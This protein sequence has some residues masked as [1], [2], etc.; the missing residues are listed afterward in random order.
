MV[1]RPAVTQKLT[2]RGFFKYGLRLSVLGLLGFGFS[3]R[4][5]IETKQLN[6]RFAN[7][8]EAFDGFRIVQIS[9]LHASFWVGK[10]YLDRVIAR[11][12]TLNKDLVVITGDIITGSV[13]DF[14][15]RWL[16]SAG[17]GYI[18]VVTDVLTRLNAGPRFAVLGNHD[19][20]DGKET[21]TQL[22]GELERIGIDVLRNRSKT[23]NRGKDRITIAGTDDVWFTYDI[24][25]A[26]KGVPTGNFTI[27]LCHSPDVREDLDTGSKVELVLCG[28]THGGQ[29]AVPFL[30]HHFI[31]IKRPKRYL[32]GLVKE[33]Y[34]YTYVNRGIG[35]L[36]FPLRIGAPPEITSIKLIRA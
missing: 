8:P 30:S 31:P 3:G 2:R 6:L 20:W 33:R 34:G 25:R 29:V 18:P 32:A 7:L 5:N 21:E 22:V 27:V 24:D 13:N 4:N 35:T 14:W 17:G 12:N 36:V 1:F 19:Q 28:H 16:P 9:D 10:R 11:V 23:I 26:L 15:K